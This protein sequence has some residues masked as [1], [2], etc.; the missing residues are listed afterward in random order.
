VEDFMRRLALIISL[1]A[2]PLAAVADECRFSA[3][4]VLDVDASGVR[5]LKLDTGAGDLDVV[6]VPG[7]ARIEVRGK[8]CASEEATLAGIQFAQQREGAVAGVGTKIPKEGSDWTLFGS[9]YAYLDVHVRMPA[10]L[11]LDLRDSSGDLVV[12]GLTGGVD[13][14]DSSG[15]ITLH[16]LGG[17]VSVTDTSGDIDVRGVDGNFTIVSDS[18]GD[19]R[20]TDV[21]GDAVVREDSSGDI[22]FNHVTGSARVERDSSGDITFDDIGRDA[23]VGSD[24][25]GTIRADH[26]R[27]NFTVESKSR[28]KDTI[29]YSD[30]GGKT[31]IPTD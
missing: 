5:T 16:D 10:G 21:R 17:A 20:I 15:D 2:L 26:V 8:A 11:K 18:S 25:S 7:L 23:G 1:T 14:V 13:L 24:S 22:D 30:I 19:I 4:R 29:V 12:A 9:H 3:E 27:G 31:S 6:G 28:A